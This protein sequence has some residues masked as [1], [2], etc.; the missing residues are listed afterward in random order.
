MRGLRRPAS[1]EAFGIRARCE[2]FLFGFEGV[3]RDSLF[4]FR[5]FI[6]AGDYS[7]EATPVPIPNTAV[8]LICADDTW[9]AAARENRSSPAFFMRPYGQA[10]KTLPFHGS[11]PGSSPGR[12]TIRNIL[13]DTAL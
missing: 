8:K 10:V 3:R 1:P 5:P 9:R 6:R 7:N 11:N 13:A 2:R 4:P 12:V